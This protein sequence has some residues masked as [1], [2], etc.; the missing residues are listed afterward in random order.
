MKCQ[1]YFFSYVDDILVVCRCIQRNFLVFTFMSKYFFKSLWQRETYVSFFHKL[2]FKHRKAALDL[3]FLKTCQDFRV[4]P[5]FLQFH[6][7]NDSL[8]QSHRLIKHAK[9]GCCSKKSESRRKI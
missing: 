5:K 9:I 6:V 3:Q 4:T 1:F 2:D 8:K 7:A